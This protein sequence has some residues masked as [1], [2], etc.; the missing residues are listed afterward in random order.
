[1]GTSVTV[2][3]GVPGPS[4]VVR[5]K[6]QNWLLVTLQTHRSLEARDSAPGPR[7]CSSAAPPPAPRPAAPGAERLPVPLAQH[8]VSGSLEARA[9]GGRTAGA[10]CRR[11]KRTRGVSRLEGGARHLWCVA[12]RGW[13]PQL[14]AR[15]WRR[16]AG[17]EVR[18]HRGRRPALGR[19]LLPLPKF[20]PSE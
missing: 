11:P 10:R 5:A 8:V 2:D 16:R 4:E 7:R 14:D 20:S 15:G 12:G 6:E 19:T 18:P 9:G 17:E 3:L 13:G 1:M